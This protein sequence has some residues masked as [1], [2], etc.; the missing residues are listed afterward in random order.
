[1][2]CYC[3]C[4]AAAQKEAKN[5]V[6]RLQAAYAR[7]VGQHT[8]EESRRWELETEVERLRAYVSEIEDQRPRLEQLHENS[9][10]GTVEHRLAEA[11]LSALDVLR[12]EKVRE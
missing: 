10:P 7:V 12:A 5:Q 3:Y 2:E 9:L 1:M 6:E 4:V 11:I 8:E